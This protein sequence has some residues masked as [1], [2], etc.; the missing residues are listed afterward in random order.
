MNDSEESMHHERGTRAVATSDR[1]HQDSGGASY[2][3]APT[4]Q[5][6]INQPQS[7]IEAAALPVSDARRHLTSP[8]SSPELIRPGMPYRGYARHPGL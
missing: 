2:Y 4:H 6:T 3:T 7:M 8:A 5:T 1:D